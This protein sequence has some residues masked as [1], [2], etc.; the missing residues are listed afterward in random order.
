ML[1]RRGSRGLVA[2]AAGCGAL[3]LAGFAVWKPGGDPALDA[4]VPAVLE[5]GGFVSSDTCR[6]CHPDAYDAWHRSYHRSMTQRATP[7]TVL[8]RFDDVTL[9]SRGFTTRLERRGDEFWA[10]MADPL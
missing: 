2:V 9:E 6:A 3:A 1:A 4:A 7:Q 5:E 8:A 10:D